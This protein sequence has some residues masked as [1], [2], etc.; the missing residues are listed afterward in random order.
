MQLSS[1]SGPGGRRPKSNWVTGSGDGKSTSHPGQ[2]PGHTDEETGPHRG[3]IPHTIQVKEDRAGANDRPDSYTVLGER[4]TGSGTPVPPLGH[5]REPPAHPA[6][7]P[8]ST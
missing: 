7:S 6:G 4:K 2:T 8:C 1:A 3:Q 5:G